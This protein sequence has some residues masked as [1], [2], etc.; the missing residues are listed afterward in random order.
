[1]HTTWLTFTILG[2]AAIVQTALDFNYHNY[3]QMTIF[4]QTIAAQY[5]TSA[6]LYKVGESEGGRSLW[7][8]AL[9]ASSP[10]EHLLLRPE[11]KY[12]G[13]MHGNEVVG[14]EVLLHLIEYL[15]TSNDVQVQKVMTLSRIHIMP[16]MNPDGFEMSHNGDC[17]SAVGR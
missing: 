13:N 5:P 14:R 17:D 10:N 15:L 8:M 2:A 3:S 16:S 12:I 4:L 11:V 1:M 9:S 7:A 6:Y